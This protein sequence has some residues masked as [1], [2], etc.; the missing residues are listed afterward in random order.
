MPARQSPTRRHWF[1]ISFSVRQKLSQQW[2][3]GGVVQLTSAAT[4]C[5]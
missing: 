5:G 1:A 2:L 4:Y 3:N